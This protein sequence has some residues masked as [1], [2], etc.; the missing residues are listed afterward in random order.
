MSHWSDVKCDLKC[1]IDVMR[2]ALINV[3]PEWERFIHVSTEGTLAIKN[4]Y[5]SNYGRSQGAEAARDGQYHIAIPGGGNSNLGA[6]APGLSYADI[7][8]RKNA[9]GTWTITA[10]PMGHNKLRN[11]NG[12]LGAQV[13]QMRAQVQAQLTGNKILSTETEE[14]GTTITDIEINLDDDGMMA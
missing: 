7:G 3:F 6:S 12:R 5:M 8:L 10:D 13:E 1:S 9:D 14:D 4:S 11:L 2:R